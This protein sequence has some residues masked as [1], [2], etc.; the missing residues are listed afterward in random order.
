MFKYAIGDAYDFVTYIS[1]RTYL[2]AA[3]GT[4]VVSIITSYILTKKI[5]KIDMVKSLKAND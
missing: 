4:F 5:K 2:L 3:L 1:S